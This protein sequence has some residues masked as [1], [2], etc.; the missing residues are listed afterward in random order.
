MTFQTQFNHFRVLFKHY[1][2]LGIHVHHVA[3]CEPTALKSLQLP[4][5]V[6]NKAIH[7][8]TLCLFAVAKTV[9]ELCP[10]KGVHVSILP[11]NWIFS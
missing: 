5:F 11:Q 3:K 1:C 8:L 9:L 4:H 2:I 6:F 10:N 7:V